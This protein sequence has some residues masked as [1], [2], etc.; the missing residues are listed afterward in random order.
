MGAY[1]V[2]TDAYLGVVSVYLNQAGHVSIYLYKDGLQ[3]LLIL[4]RESTH[5]LPKTSCD[6][7]IY[8]AS[9]LR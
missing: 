3:K 4:P 2:R 1:L 9:S 5:S 6:S 8:C 7:V